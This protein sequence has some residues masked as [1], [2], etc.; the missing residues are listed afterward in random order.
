M[1]YDRDIRDTPATDSVGTNNPATNPHAEQI[2][3]GTPIFDAAGEKIGD[4]DDLGFQ[5]GVLKAR[6]SGVFSRDMAIPL[7]VI[8]RTDAGGVHLTVTK[9]QLRGMSDSSA[10]KASA[11]HTSA[12][13][14]RKRR[15]RPNDMATDTGS[16]HA[17]LDVPPPHER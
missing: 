7:D 3:P 9:D 11:A 2:V 16:P 13:P 17:D 6:Q 14:M 5:D 4:V 12:K 1:A 8:A 10:E 15:T